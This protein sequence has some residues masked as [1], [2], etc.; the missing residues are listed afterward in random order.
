MVSYQKKT[1]TTKQTNIDLKNRN[2]EIVDNL[3]VTNSYL[4]LLW[5]IKVTL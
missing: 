4:E 2:L 3:K 5:I 1:T